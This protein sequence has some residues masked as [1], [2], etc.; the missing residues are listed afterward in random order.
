[1]HRV[2][3]VLELKAPL[4]A[5][6]ATKGGKVKFT[7]VLCLGTVEEEVGIE[8]RRVTGLV[9]DKNII[10]AEA[11]PGFL[12]FASRPTQREWKKAASLQASVVGREIRNRAR[13]LAAQ[14]VDSV[15]A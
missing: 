8:T 3:Q 7:P 12:G 11:T 6:Y 13:R 14:A 2:I 15:R 10:P 4:F 1:M 5:V 9:V